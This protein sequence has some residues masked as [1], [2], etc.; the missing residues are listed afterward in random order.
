ML[1]KWEARERQNKRVALIVSVVLHL[2]IIGVVTQRPDK[3]S[4]EQI[5]QV[6]NHSPEQDKIDVKV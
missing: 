5:E 4:V 1:N 6:K 2:V 3:N